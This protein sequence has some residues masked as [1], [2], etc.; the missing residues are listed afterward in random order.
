VVAVCQQSCT[1][2]SLSCAAAINSHCLI[3]DEADQRCQRHCPEVIHYLWMKESIE[4]FITG[5]GDTE[6]TEEHY[7][8]ASQIFYPTVAIGELLAGPAVTRVKAMPRGIAVAASP[9]L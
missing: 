3:A 6:E 7:G 5:N 9:K 2:D 8:Q 1:F 4:G